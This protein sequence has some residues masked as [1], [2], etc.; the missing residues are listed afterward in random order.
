M[1]RQMTQDTP[2]PVAVPVTFEV[3]IA[4]AQRLLYVAEVETNLAVMERLEKLADSW[5][6]IAGLAIRRERDTP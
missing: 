4:N 1:E 2:Q 5:V 6:N 3:A